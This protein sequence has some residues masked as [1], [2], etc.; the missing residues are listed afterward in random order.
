MKRYFY[1]LLLVGVFAGKKVD[2]QMG[3]AKKM[4]LDVDTLISFNAPL[5]TVWKLVKDPAKWNELSNNYVTKIETSGD[6]ESTLVRNITFA[7]GATRTD[8][9][10]Q[11]MPQYYFIVNKV[12][13]PLP[14]GISDNIYM[15]SLQSEP[16]KGTQMKY[17][18]KVDGDDEGKQQL[19][20]TLKKE[21]NYFIQGV[22]TALDNGS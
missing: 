1:F 9:V 19:L 16:G 3:E 18:I 2:A 17:S 13:S 4:V 14:K 11:F 20:K 21:M 12:S 22:K 7:D 5:Q 10:T 15:F 8:E 6:L